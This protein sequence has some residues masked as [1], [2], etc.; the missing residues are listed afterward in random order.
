MA[1]ESKVTPRECWRS[2]VEIEDRMRRCLKTLR[3]LQRT[4]KQEA[5]LWLPLV[6]A[7]QRIS[8]SQDSRPRRSEA[9]QLCRFLDEVLARIEAHG[10]I[11]VDLES[12][13][14]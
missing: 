13:S 2:Y 11:E 4:S 6:E 1:I 9:Q 7:L 8:S 5:A 12:L 10:R 14:K 3:S